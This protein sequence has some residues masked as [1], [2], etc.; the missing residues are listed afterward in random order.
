MTTFSYHPR[1]EGRSD[2][3]DRDKLTAKRLHI[4]PVLSASRIILL[5]RPCKLKAA[6]T[7]DRNARSPSG[8]SNTAFSAGA[9]GAAM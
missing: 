1:A 7:T 6:A 9:V 5:K 8:P 2:T 3:R 4:Q